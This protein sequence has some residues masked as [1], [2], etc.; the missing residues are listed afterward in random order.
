MSYIEVTIK[1]IQS[2]DNLNIVKFDLL[3]DELT[4]MS[5]ELSN[6]IIVGKKVKLVVK[7]TYIT[8]GK[9]FIGEL[10]I[11][12]QLKAKIINIE[13]G[14]LLSSIILKLHDTILE[15]IITVASSIS[16]DL[17]IDDE[18]IVM[19]KASDLSILEVI[20]D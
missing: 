16:M 15:S 13:N 11:S 4:M 1:D 20:N 19:I 2:V 3:E 6:K 5:L 10:S 17:Q 9:K 18:V 12:N 14:K 7:P 8:I